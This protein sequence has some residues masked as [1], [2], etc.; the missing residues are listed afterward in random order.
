MS[1]RAQKLSTQLCQT[2]V[3]LS[4]FVDCLQTLSDSANNIK[5]A[6]RDIGAALTRFCLRQR[7][8]Q[9]DLKHLST[10]I[11]DG[12][13]APLER[14]SAEWKQSA[15]D[16]ER[17]QHRIGKKKR[18]KKDA[19]AEL[20]NEQKAFATDL[21]LGQRQVFSGFMHLTLP[22]IVSGWRGSGECFRRNFRS[23][24]G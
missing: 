4:N 9:S 14:K 7:T 6:S 2:A 11:N 20:L 10:A 17:R 23:N 12:F 15:A 19:P 18:A 21:L 5:G 3:C 1:G 16:L 8:L 24:F 22:V 13:C